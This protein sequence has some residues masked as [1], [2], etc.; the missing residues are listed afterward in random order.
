MPA[1]LWSPIFWKDAA[2]RAVAAG[3]AAAISAWALGWSGAVP[4]MPGQA[5]LGAFGAGIGLDILRS[6]T[7]LKVGPGQ[8]NGTASPLAEVVAAPKPAQA[9]GDEASL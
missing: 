5:V 9:K 1:T 2:D 4:S 8:E 6:L 7:T 3:A